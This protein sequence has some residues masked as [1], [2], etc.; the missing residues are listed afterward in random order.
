MPDAFDRGLTEVDFLER[1]L[2]DLD[3]LDAEVEGRGD[4]A[5]AAVGAGVGGAAAFGALYGLGT[6]GLGA[7]GVSSGLAAAG[8]LVGGGVM[9]GVGVLA[10]PVAVLAAGGFA[11]A[12]HRRRR[13]VATLQS[14]VLAKAVTRQSEVLRCLEADSGATDQQRVELRARNDTLAEIIRRLGRLTESD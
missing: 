8:A 10:A 6:T 5:G 7:V 2:A 12:R 14:Q 4:V 13:R 9:A 11:V 1:L 3:L